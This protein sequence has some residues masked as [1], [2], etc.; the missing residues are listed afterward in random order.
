M[1]DDYRVCLLGQFRL[2]TSGREV[3]QLKGRMWE[4]MLAY[5]ALHHGRPIARRDLAAALWPERP[6]ELGRNRVSCELGRIRSAL[7]AAGWP[8]DS[9][10]TSYHAIVLRPDIE[11][12]VARFEALCGR[13]ESESDVGA[14]AKLAAEALELY[15]CGLN[16]LLLDDFADRRRYDLLNQ[17]VAMRRLVSDGLTL[18]GPAGRLDLVTGEPA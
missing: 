13:V 5:L 7:E 3:A 17:E 14:R 18:G 4:R 9:V 12:D 15:G 6:W 11:T 1:T 16:P 2:E 10:W 8:G